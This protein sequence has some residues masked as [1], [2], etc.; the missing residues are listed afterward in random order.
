MDKR[1]RKKERNIDNI[2]KGREKQREDRMRE[3][4]GDRRKK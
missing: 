1:E 4:V 2:D 3:R